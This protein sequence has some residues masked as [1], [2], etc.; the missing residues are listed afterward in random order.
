MT[1]AVGQLIDRFRR[2]AD[3]QRSPADTPDVGIVMG[4]DSDLPIMRG[5]GEALTR[6]GFQET[7]ADEAVTGRSFETYVVSAHRTPELMYAYAETA[8]DRGLD[9]IIAGAGGKSADLP[10]MVAS[11]AMPLPV[12]GVPVQEKSVDSVIGMPTGAPI[13][14]VD[15]GKAFNAGLAAAQILA[16][17]DEELA[18][19]LHRF[20][21]DQ[22]EKVG[23]TA[24]RLHELG[25]DAYATGNQGE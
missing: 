1:D 16:T 10:N 18:E 19:R 5:A 7:T 13:L 12:V 21:T 17:E 15:A 22:R 25:I 6:L 4:S 9:V 8:R 3:A 2:A 23:E 24:T 14:A 11:I 20:Y